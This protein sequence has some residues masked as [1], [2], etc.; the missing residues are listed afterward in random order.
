MRFGADVALVLL[1][2]AG[3]SRAHEV[4]DNCNVKDNDGN[5][6]FDFTPLFR[7]YVAHPVWLQQTCPRKPFRASW[8][9]RTACRHAL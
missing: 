7:G 1:L 4:M 3:V 9:L 2:A 8:A 5:V 6:L